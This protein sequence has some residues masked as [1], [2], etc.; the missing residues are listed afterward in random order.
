MNFGKKYFDVYVIWAEQQVKTGQNW[1]EAMQGMNEFEPSLMWD[2]TL[3]A[4]Q[5][6]IQNTLAAEATG[7][8]LMFEDMA[9]V[10]GLP[11][12]AIKVVDYFKDMTGQVTNVQ[13]SL[14]DRGFEMMRKAD[15]SGFVIELPQPA[16]KPAPAKA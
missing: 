16:K 13:Q 10:K 14:V 9:E 6:A 1:V 4:Y 15:V 12:E 2:K 5:A 11:Q 7:A 3:A 8:R